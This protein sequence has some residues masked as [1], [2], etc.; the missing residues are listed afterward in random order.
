MPGS[1]VYRET[2]RRLQDALAKSSARPPNRPAKMR[3]VRLD[4]IFISPDVEILRAMAPLNSL[5]RAASN[6]APVIADLR[7]PRQQ[8]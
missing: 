3:P 6:H 8:G 5:T 2:T 1:R 4:R 7:F